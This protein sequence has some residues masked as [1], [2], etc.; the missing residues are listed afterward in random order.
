MDARTLIDL[1]APTHD[2]TSCND[3]QLGNGF[4]SHTADGHPRCS[5]CALL[6]LEAGL[7]LPDRIGAT[8]SFDAA[9]LQND[10]P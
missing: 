6:E 3:T 10:A 2:R 4:Y 1:I 5:R 7:P 9:P 8:V